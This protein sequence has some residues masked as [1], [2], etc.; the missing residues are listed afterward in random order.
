MPGSVRG[1]KNTK[2]DRCDTA[3]RVAQ[4]KGK[5]LMCKLDI[6]LDGEKCCKRDQCSH[7]T[8]EAWAGAHREAV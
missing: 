6:V 8:R 3:V 7:A 5:R 2:I 1:A 4:F